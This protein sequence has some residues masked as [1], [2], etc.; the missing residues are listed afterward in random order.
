MQHGQKSNYTPISMR[1]DQS[2]GETRL[3]RKTSSTL[4]GSCGPTPPL[5][6]GT[7]LIERK[8]TTPTYNYLRP[9][10]ISTTNHKR[11]DLITSLRR[12]LTASLPA[13]PVRAA[14]VKPRG[15]PPMHLFVTGVRNQGI[16]DATAR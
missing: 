1:Y 9:S 8:S 14:I 10:Y 16:Y 11:W 3:R 6:N 13:T 5:K 12:S 2:H 15:V 7:T 4:N